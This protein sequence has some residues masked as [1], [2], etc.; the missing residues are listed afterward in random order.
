[1]RRLIACLLALLGSAAAA[2]AGGFEV[3][4]V[5][6]AMRVGQPSTV[7]TV[8]NPT[9]EPVLI[10]AEAFVW[11]QD[12]GEDVLLP[13]P[14]LLLNPPIFELAPGARQ[15]VRIGFKPGSVPPSAREASYRIWLSQLPAA[16]TD[17]DA[18]GVQ[19]LF[20][21]S[22]PLFVS[23]RQAMAAQPVWTLSGGELV[24]ANPGARHVH[25]LSL[26]LRR[27]AGERMNLNLSQRYVL[28]GAELHW[29]LPT[30]WQERA[31]SIELVTDVG[32]QTISLVPQAA[33][34]R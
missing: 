9:T 12:K 21:L 18:P 1:M 15:L 26:T 7:L 27:A 16:R 29:P 11:Q 34:V 24:L 10:Q 6:L 33:F 23:P 4:P 2:W 31:L 30:E 28:A 19:L 32:R 22:L 20:R 13:A 17:D 8:S 25:L 14:G 3:Q 5:Q